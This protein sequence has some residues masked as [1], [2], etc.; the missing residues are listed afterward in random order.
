MQIFKEDKIMTRREAREALFA[1]LYE[2][3]FND[4]SEL[5]TTISTAREMRDIEDE[6]IL[7][8]V[9]GTYKNLE[10][11]DT[12]IEENAK[13]WKISRLAKT[14]LSILRLS[15]YEMLYGG[16]PY[17]ISINEAVELAKKYDH[18]QAPVF[19]NGILNTVAQKN[20]LKNTQ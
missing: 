9:R 20:G 3:T 17:T 16:I 8:S 14:T 10:A 19:I 13:G 15:I 1:L 12:Q 6:Y 5:E 4:A 2:M 18:D 7:T 11:I